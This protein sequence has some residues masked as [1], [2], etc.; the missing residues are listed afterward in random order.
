MILYKAVN[1]G[2]ML[3]SLVDAA[4]DHVVPD[5]IDTDEQLLDPADENTE[6]MYEKRMEGKTVKPV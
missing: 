3:D 4:V 6:T 5:G 1:Y 2:A